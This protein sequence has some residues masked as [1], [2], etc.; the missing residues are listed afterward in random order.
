MA[1]TKDH[2]DVLGIMKGLPYYQGGVERHKCAACAYN[3]GYAAGLGFEDLESIDK[4]LEELEYCQAGDQR[5]KS[6]R[7]AFALGYYKGVCDS[8]WGRRS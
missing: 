7:A 4:M 2:S 8:I 6:P 3:K 1:C 5:H